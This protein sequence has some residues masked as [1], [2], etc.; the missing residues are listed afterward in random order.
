MGGGC[1][2]RDT[3]PAPLGGASGSPR[4]LF[5]RGFVDPSATCLY[6]SQRWHIV[7]NFE[8]RN[9]RMCRA[10]DQLSGQCPTWTVERAA[11]QTASVGGQEAGRQLSAWLEGRVLNSV[12]ALCFSIPLSKCR[13]VTRVSSWRGGASLS[14]DAA[15]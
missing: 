2:V 8:Q 10:G 12:S 6:L 7:E 11:L 1:C 15:L 13:P 9:S 14:L 3:P 4:C 5:R